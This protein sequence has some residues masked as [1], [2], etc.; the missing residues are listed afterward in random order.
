MTRR[1]QF[2]AGLLA[3]SGL[4]IASP[5]PNIILAMADDMGWGDPNFHGTYY[6]GMPASWSKTSLRE[7]PPLA[8]SAA[9]TTAW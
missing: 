1:L 9:P 5:R 2:L 4:A 3:Y 8:R 6:W 7:C